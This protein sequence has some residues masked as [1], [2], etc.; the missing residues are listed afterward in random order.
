M[1]YLPFQFSFKGKI[2]EVCIWGCMRDFVAHYIPYPLLA[3]PLVVR[4]QAISGLTCLLW[5]RIMQ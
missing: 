5:H 2:Q 4:I 1:K 3:V